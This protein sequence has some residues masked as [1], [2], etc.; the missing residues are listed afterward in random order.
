M[1][2]IERERAEGGQHGGSLLEMKMRIWR[3]CQMGQFSNLERHPSLFCSLC[4]FPVHSLS[5]YPRF[6]FLFPFLISSSHFSIHY[7]FS[8]ISF[9][10]TL[11][12]SLV[13]PTQF[14]FFPPFLY[15][16]PK[17]PYCYFAMNHA[18]LLVHHILN[19]MSYNH[20]LKTQFTAHHSCNL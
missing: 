4:G 12:A 9:S 13:P 1:C 18:G 2:V 17:W 6:L 10:I 5:F 3:K 8:S 15:K 20:S 7:F 11:S 19:G 16:K 14:A